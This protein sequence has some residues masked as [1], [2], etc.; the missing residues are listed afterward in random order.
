MKG[1]RQNDENTGQEDDI[2][3]SGTNAR[4]YIKILKL[5][6]SCCLHAKYNDT[7]KARGTIFFNSKYCSNLEALWLLRVHLPNSDYLQS[8]IYSNFKISYL[9]RIVGGQQKGQQNFCS[10]VAPLVPI[11]PPLC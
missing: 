7:K 2:M 1:S 4:K 10:S 3:Q 8:I 5:A 6:M 11:E 9:P